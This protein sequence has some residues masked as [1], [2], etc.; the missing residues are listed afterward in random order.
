MLKYTIEVFASVS[1]S[2]VHST[3]RD[4]RGNLKLFL[5]YQERGSGNGEGLLVEVGAREEQ[6]DVCGVLPLVKLQQ[7]GKFPQLLQV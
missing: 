5:P 6:Q 2:T 3:E 1:A 4:H 7:L